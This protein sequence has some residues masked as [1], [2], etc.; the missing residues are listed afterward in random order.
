[1]IDLPQKEKESV[2]LFLRP[3]ILVTNLKKEFR[4]HICKPTFDNTE[5]CSHR[6]V[7]SSLQYVRWVRNSSRVCTTSR[8]RQ[9][10]KNACCL[11]ISF[12][13]HLRVPTLTAASTSE[14]LSGIMESKFSVRITCIGV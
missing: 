12:E 5:R 1:L 11:E 9:P 4:R 13:T 3:F 10:D 14:P 8:H 7:N 2:R 6:D